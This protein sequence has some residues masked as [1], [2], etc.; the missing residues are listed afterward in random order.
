M[1]DEYEAIAK[2]FEHE[3]Q[4]HMHKNQIEVQPHQLGRCQTREVRWRQEYSAPPKNGRNGDSQP[5][6]HCPDLK[7]SQ[8]LRQLRRCENLVATLKVIDSWTQTKQFREIE[9]GNA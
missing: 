5:D 2:Q 8:W 7:H 4:L 9:Y 6:F 3:T 1:S